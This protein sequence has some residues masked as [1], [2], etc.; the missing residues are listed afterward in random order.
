MSENNFLPMPEPIP[1]NL[2]ERA[3]KLNSALLCDGLKGMGVALDG[4]MDASIKPVSTKSSF[5]VG[6]AVTVETCDGDNFPIH[7]ATYSAQNA[8]KGYVMVFDGKG[9]SKCAYAGGLIVGAAQAIGYADMVLDGCVRD[10]V[11]ITELGLPVF[12]R[13]YSQGGP[14][15]KNPGKMNHP[16]TCAGVSVNP[17]DLV[18]GGADG[19]TVVPRKL[20]EKVLDKA[21]EKAAYEVRR[22]E[23]IAEYRRASQAGEP[24]PELAPDWVVE[25]LAAKQ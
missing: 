24:L 25:M 14:T 8:Q 23:V 1:A 20:I 10:Q 21:E 6:T 3:S 5:M 2:L 15:K 19:V 7:V 17:G 4:C 16:I 12:S 22:E 13:G 9:Y 18:M 11:D